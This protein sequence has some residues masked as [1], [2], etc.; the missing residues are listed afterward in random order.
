MPTNILTKYF[1]LYFYSLSRHIRETNVSGFPNSSRNNSPGKQI[2]RGESKQISWRDLNGNSFSGNIHKF[3]CKH[4]LR[5]PC[6]YVF[7]NELVVDQTKWRDQI[8]LDRFLKWNILN[9]RYPQFYN[10]NFISSFWIIFYGYR[11]LLEYI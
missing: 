11:N 5:E 3:Y 10:F 8:I 1:A 2:K 4:S 9:S 6:K 7:W